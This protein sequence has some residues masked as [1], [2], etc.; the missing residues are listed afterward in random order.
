MKTNN[1]NIKRIG[2]AIS[3]LI[4]F[5]SCLIT[6]SSCNMLYTESEEKLSGSEF[7][8][9]ADASDVQSFMN[10]LYFYLRDATMNKSAFFVFCG[11]LRCAPIASN[12]SNNNRPYVTCLTENDLNTLRSK[13]S[14]DNDYRADAIMR[15]GNL[16]KVIQSANIV[17][18][19]LGQTSV[20]GTQAQ[21]FR[22][23]AVFMR[24][25]TYFLLVRNF[26]DVPYYTNAYNSESLARTPMVTV[27]QNINAD[28][29]QVLDN[30][31]LPMTWTGSNKAVKASKGSVLALMMHVNMWLASFDS[32]NAKSYYQTVVD[33]GKQLVDDN[34]GAY[35]LVPIAE[36][37]GTVF[38]GSSDEG[39]F[40][41]AQ[42]VSY[43]AGGEVFKK[44]CVFSNYVSYK[45]LST[46]YP[47]VY[48]NYDFMTKVFPASETDDR[49]TYWFDKNAYST[50]ANDY[51]EIVKFQNVD[52]YNG[53]VTSD[54]G[55]QVIFRL[56]DAILL[57]AE[58]LANL[59]TDD[60]KACQLLNQV[61]ARAH[62][63]EQTLTGENLKNAIYWE[64]VREL[65]GEGQY[66]YDLVRTQKILDNNYCWHTMTRSQYNKGAWTW[67]ISRSALNNNTKMTLNAYWE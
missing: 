5:S 52:T 56:A 37:T 51:R 7:W 35:S 3:Y 20:S 53:T 58:A 14:S 17:L 8:Y 18:E 67:P 27:L 11:D 28:L 44:E 38:K 16:Y 22:D 66:F 10:S 15:W 31:V 55:N 42:N 9:D 12:Y 30:N 41:L 65:I 6:T 2:K 19:E 59:G 47:E 63:S 43:G 60:T 36:M 46:T 57:Y 48:Y 50:V 24:S 26:G 13:Y 62:A 40:E 34:D 33:C 25:L 32:S 4:V 21:Q 39:I 49:V 45:S 54:A 23:E 29:K 61:R 1:K 64:R